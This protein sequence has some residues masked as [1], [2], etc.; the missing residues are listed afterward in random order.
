MPPDVCLL[1]VRSLKVGYGGKVIA[2]VS[3]LAFNSACVTVIAGPNGAGKSTLL[4]SL[5]R[6]QRP[7]SGSVLFDGKDIFAMSESE[8]ARKVAYVP[9]LVSST[10]QLSVYEW[11]ALGRNPH[12]NWWSWRMSQADEEAVRLALERTGSWELKDRIVDTLSGG[13]RQRVYISMALAQQTRYLIL[14]E[15]TAHLDFRHQLE[16]SDLLRQLASEGLGVII[17]LHDLNLIARLADQVVFL[18]QGSDKTSTVVS[19]GAKDKI[20]ERNTLRKVYEVEVEILLDAER[21]VSGFVPTRVAD[22]DR[23]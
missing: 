23:G 2:D 18:K 3:D 14:D 7:L 17:V 4:K 20:L 13:E 22:P 10:R 9:Q 1:E 16:L 15:P 8:F 6:Q 21:G 12:Q 5:V 19:S 11:A